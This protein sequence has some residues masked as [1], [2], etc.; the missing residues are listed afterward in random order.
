MLQIALVTPHLP[1][2]Q[3]RQSLAGFQS[4]LTIL[5]LGMH[6][7]EAFDGAGDGT[8]PQRP[9]GRRSLDHPRHPYRVFAKHTG[10]DGIS[11]APLPQR[12]CEAAGATRI[13]EADLDLPVSM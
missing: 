11:L 8:Q 5:F 4:M 9:R 10:I 6:N 3:G 13:Y 7:A 1:N 2:Q 12:F